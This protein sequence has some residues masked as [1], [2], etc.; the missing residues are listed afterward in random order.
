[1]KVTDK[2]GVTFQLLK[3]KYLHLS[4][5]QIKE[6]VFVDSTFLEHLSQKEKQAWLALQ[7]VCENFLVNNKSYDYVAHVEEFLSA[8][9]AMGCNMIL[10]IHF[11]H[12][13]LDFFP[14]DL[15]AVSD[16]HGKRFHQDIIKVE[17]KLSGKWTASM[18]AEYC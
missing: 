9:R 13:H 1:M 8:Y 18:L 10:K 11:L 6:G 17:R 14:E 5:A 4:E 15:G 7:N 2:T 16:E 12:S 3:T